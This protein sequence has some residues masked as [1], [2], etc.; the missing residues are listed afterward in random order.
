MMAWLAF[1]II[2]LVILN[3]GLNVVKSTD[4][5]HTVFCSPSPSSAPRRCSFTSTPSS[6]PL[7]RCCCIPAVW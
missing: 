6:S 5:V 7:S 1:S 3:S 2:A 4:L